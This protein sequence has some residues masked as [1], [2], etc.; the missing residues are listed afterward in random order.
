MITQAQLA[1]KLGVSQQ[2][3]SFAL[4]GSGTL[5]Q[6]TRERILK[7][8]A[9]LGYRKNMASLTMQTGKTR[10]VGLLV[11][12]AARS[13]MPQPLI[14]GASTWLEDNDHTL[15]IV[16][17]SDKQLAGEEQAP[18]V[19]REHRVDGGLVL[20]DPE[21]ADRL[22][23]M[24][25]ES[26]MP[27]IWINQN[28]EH[29]ACYPDDEFLGRRG[30]GILLER[31]CQRVAYAGRVREGG[32]Y[33]VTDRREGYLSAIQAAG[34][35]PILFDGHQG[36][37]GA[38]RF[39]GQDNLPDGIVCYGPGDAENLYV[40]ARERGL[41]IPEDLKL[42]SIGDAGAAIGSVLLAILRIPLYYV[43]LRAMELLEQRME[44]DDAD[45]DSL[46]VRYEEL[47]VG[48]TL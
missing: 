12:G 26:R 5:A 33:S 39:L 1:K 36:M 7:E 38:R 2:A 9:R 8:A 47:D 28:F 16:S 10:S 35:E 18:L 15:S 23:P 42:L 14:M 34:K 32:H 17:V 40:A 4:N 37:E 11:R 41:R 44:N 29:N 3:V 25:D 21:H 6:A 19:F 30:T 27:W 43:G 13:R 31:G 20:L 48:D 45:V 22:I 46:A 24:L